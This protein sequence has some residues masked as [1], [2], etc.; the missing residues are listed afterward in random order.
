MVGRGMTP[1]ELYAMSD[2]LNTQR[3]ALLAELNTTRHFLVRVMAFR[4]HDIVRGS[5]HPAQQHE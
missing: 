4:G 2:N 5:M 1:A 3:M